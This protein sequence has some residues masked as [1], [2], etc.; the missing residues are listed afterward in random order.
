MPWTNDAVTVYHGTDEYS[1]N[2]IMRRGV[3]LSICNPLCDFGRGF[4][5]TT[6]LHQAQQWANKRALE[7]PT[8]T[9]ARS[10]V[11][12]F[13]LDRE[14]ISNFGDH[15]SFVVPTSDFFEFAQ[16]N[17]LGNSHHSR[18]GGVPYDVVYGPVAAYPQTLV[19]LACDQICLLSQRALSALIL[20]PGNPGLGSPYFV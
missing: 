11:L 18:A 20:L 9:R 2:N 5:L 12:G 19:Y 17:R 4:Y 6:N 10:A 16:F 1:A 3:N 13:S 8:A 15:L 14:V 7:I